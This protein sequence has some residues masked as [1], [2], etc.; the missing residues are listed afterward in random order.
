MFIHTAVLKTNATMLWYSAVSTLQACRY[1]EVIASDVRWVCLHWNCSCWCLQALSDGSVARVSL[2]LNSLSSVVDSVIH[3]DWEVII[4]CS[5]S[6]KLNAFTFM[7][8]H[9]PRYVYVH[10][11]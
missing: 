4:I 9:G 3:M 2:D 8:T 10:A 1:H 7:H 5:G 6:C 11:A